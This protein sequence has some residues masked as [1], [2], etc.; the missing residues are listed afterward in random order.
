MNWINALSWPQWLLLAA[1]PPAVL[2]LYFLKLKRKR[3]EVSS[4]LLWRKTLEDIHVNS[5]WQRLRKNLLLY[6]QL[7]FLALLILAC[8]RPG[9]S[10]QDRIGERRIYVIDNSASMQATDTSPSR[11]ELAK[12]KVKNLLSE[13]AS[14]DVGMVIAF[15]DRADVRQGFTKDKTRLLAAVDSI[16]PTNHPT[17]ISEALRAAAGLANPGRSSFDNLSDIQVADA[18]PA[19]VYLLSDG[20]FGDLGDSDLGQLKVEFLPI[21]ETGTANVGVL[22]FAVQRNEDKKN[23][24][25]AFARIGN[26]GEEPVEFTASLEINGELVDASSVKVAA[27]QETGILFELEQ[28]EEGE[29]ALKLDHEDALSIDNTAYAAI[30]PNKPISVLLVT[31][32]NSALETA[33]T[34][35]RCQRIANV[36]VESPT[37]LID[38]AYLA[39]DTE[40]LFDLI[41]FD[42]CAPTMMPESNT[43]FMGSKPPSLSE[44]KKDSDESKKPSEVALGEADFSKDWQFGPSSGPVIILDVNR[45]NP[46]T[47]YLEM[48]SVVILEGMTVTPPENGTV[49]M[50]SDSGPV[51]AVAPRGPFQDAV[52]GFGMLQSTSEGIQVNSD[53]SIKRSFPVFVYSVV[54]YLGGGITETSAPTVLPGNAIGLTLSNRFDNYRVVSPT[55]QKIEL[56]RN[57]ESRFTFTQTDQ[58]GMYSVFADE[59]ERPME[60]FCVNLFS[61][62]ESELTVASAI[63]MGADK[64]EATS[65]FVRARQEL[66]RWILG[67]GLVVLM[68]EWV[69]FNRRIFI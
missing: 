42:Q 63:Q 66:W 45:S 58:V 53:W 56:T 22:S 54:E 23:Q 27:K 33:L 25:E 39:N 36:R 32:G 43:L 46:M 10:G 55:G 1:I 31:P 15:S 11:L 5:I 35:G 16:Q 69:I 19:T 40:S 13:T 64:I 8:L 49:L 57:N 7:A 62:R 51:F 50:T 4:T 52:L 26:F 47:Q 65:N 44:P 3:L 17:D 41:I 20:G 18:I 61:G 30:R 28:I 24:L 60:R 9:W 67:V 68:V 59:M 29:L 14:D 37:F 38:S 12:E 6:L 34:T 48:G 21:G 2:S